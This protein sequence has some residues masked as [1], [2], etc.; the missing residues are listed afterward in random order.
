MGERG[1]AVLARRE[2]VG[3]LAAATVAGGRCR[4]PGTRRGALRGHGRGKRGQKSGNEHA[5]GRGLQEPGD[6][7]GSSQ[8]V[9]EGAGGVPWHG[10]T[11]GAEVGPD[12]T[13]GTPAIEHEHASLLNPLGADSWRSPEKKSERSREEEG[14]GRSRIV[15]RYVYSTTSVRR[16]RSDRS[17]GAGVTEVQHDGGFPESGE[18]GARSEVRSGTAALF[19]A[20]VP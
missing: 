3:A 9:Q 14:I 12:V 5:Y 17:T 18:T 16:R 19:A 2:D 15:C 10:R 4:R 13:A 20:Q 11:S 6:S 8:S 1:V 7:A